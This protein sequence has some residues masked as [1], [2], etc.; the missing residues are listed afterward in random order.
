MHKYLIYYSILNLIFLNIL[1]LN[2]QILFLKFICFNSVKSKG[3]KTVIFSIPLASNNIFSNFLNLTLLIIF[4][5]D[6]LLY[7]KS[8]YFN[9]SQSKFSNLTF[10][11][12]F[13]LNLTFLIYQI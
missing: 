10:E 9:S 8:K 12:N 6:N 13:H 3:S 7:L 1:N 5:S 11:I 2:F 4:I